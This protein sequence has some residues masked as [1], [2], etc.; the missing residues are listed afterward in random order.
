[1]EDPEPEA[2]HREGRAGGD[3]GEEEEGGEG[4]AG[5]GNPSPALEPGGEGWVC[6]PQKPPG[7]SGSGVDGSEV[8][9]DC[10]LVEQYEGDGPR[11][12]GRRPGTHL[13]GAVGK[14]ST[15]GQAVSRTCRSL[16][17]HWKTVLNQS[18]GGE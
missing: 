8:G 5:Q 10:Q 6:D 12:T 18:V 13:Q 4:A 2:G 9:E 14:L 1:M 7:Q 3:E 11:A 17:S 16:L 15:K